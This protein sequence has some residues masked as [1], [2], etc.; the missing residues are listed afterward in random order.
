MVWGLSRDYWPVGT[1]HV[2]LRTI[3][4][5]AIAPILAAA[6]LL[7]ILLI[8]E[9]V[10]AGRIDIWQSQTWYYAPIILIGSFTV[11]LSGGV[12]AFLLLWS[13]RLRGRLGYILAGFAVGA[14]LSFMFLVARDEPIAL[15]SIALATIHLGVV[16]LVFRAI[17]GIRRID[18]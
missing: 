13:L 12:L 8:L 18:G 14:S 4:A 5:F 17:A 3:A 9:M 15:T 1:R 2:A 7:T 10:L 11:T 16:M 6:I